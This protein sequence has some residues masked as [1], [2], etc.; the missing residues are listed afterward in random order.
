MK[1]NEKYSVYSIEGNTFDGIKVQALLE[2]EKINP[3]G[4]RT[5]EEALNWINEEGF[6]QVDYT[7]L[8]VFRKK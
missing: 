8:Q 5:Y 3:F 1:K 4:F 2:P 6:R 7:I